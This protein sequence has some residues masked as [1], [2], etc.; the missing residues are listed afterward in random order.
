MASFPSIAPVYAAPKSQKGLGTSLSLGDGYNILQS[1][2]LNALATSWELTFEISPADA[3]TIDSFLQ[4]QGDSGDKFQWQPPDGNAEVDWQCKQWFI[5]QTSHNWYRVRAKFERVYELTGDLVS[6]SLVCDPQAPPQFDPIAGNWFTYSSAGTET[7]GVYTSPAVY[8]S[9]NTIYATGGKQTSAGNSNL[10]YLGK[11]G[12]DGNAVWSKQYTFSDGA[13]TS[14]TNDW[15]TSLYNNDSNTI[16]AYRLASAAGGVVR[17]YKVT[18]DKST[19]EAQDVLCRETALAGSPGGTSIHEVGN[20]VWV[21]V[22]NMQGVP[23][24]VATPYADIS[25]TFSLKKSDF[26]VNWTIGISVGD[27]V[28]LGGGSVRCF[29]YPLSTAITSTFNNPI[30][31]I[32]IKDDFVWFATVREFMRCDPSTGVTSTAFTSTPIS[33]A[34]NTVDG[35]RFSD[36]LF[37]GGN[38]I[39]N[40]WDA[41][42]T[43]QVIGPPYGIVKMNE[44]GTVI[45][46]HAS[47]S[48]PLGSDSIGGGGVRFILRDEKLVYWVG[49]L[50]ANGKWSIKFFLVN[51]DTLD[52]IPDTGKALNFDSVGDSGKEVYLLPAENNSTFLIATKRKGYFRMDVND[53]PPSG[54]YDG[55]YLDPNGYTIT[56]FNPVRITSNAVFQPPCTTRGVGGFS[57]DGSTGADDT[58]RSFPVVVNSSLINGI[59]VTA[60]DSGLVTTGVGGYYTVS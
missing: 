14:N 53:L 10:F 57:C 41:G 3:S 5:Q 42:Q 31:S 12:V 60:S 11:I 49:T 34:F 6:E 28:D 19:G 1:F 52:P 8:D 21:T 9:D 26:S 36:V 16:T 32:T 46:D 20:D 51:P 50:E 38:A 58:P 24:C 44:T 59:T 47:Y 40:F 39:V 15:N 29:T 7:S 56:D 23:S 48:M 43:A 33:E 55:G 45:I 18:I 30:D 25:V 13:T 27:R 35:Y 2:G 54:D 22:R 17:I 4:S 37:Y